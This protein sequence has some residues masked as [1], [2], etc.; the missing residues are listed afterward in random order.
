MALWVY[1]WWWSGITKWLYHL[2]WNANDSSGNSA[3]GTATN[4]VWSSGIIGSWSALLSWTNSNIVVNSN[5][6]YTNSSNNTVHIIF[7]QTNN[8]WTQYIIDMTNNIS[9]L[10]RIVL[11]SVSWV[12]YI[13]SWWASWYSTWYNIPLNQKVYCI[14][15]HSP[16]QDEIYI[17]AKLQYTNTNVWAWSVNTNQFWIW[18]PVDNL[19]VAQFIWKIDEVFIENTWWSLNSIRKQYTYSKGWF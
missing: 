6:W 4:I 12:L 11:Y 16:T 7:I 13:Y 15:K 10:K 19:S 1:L 5:L 9:W 8:T 14:L 2:D 18:T 3:N 17:N